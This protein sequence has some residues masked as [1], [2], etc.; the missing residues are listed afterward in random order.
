MVLIFLYP[1]YCMYNRLPNQPENIKLLIYFIFMFIVCLNVLKY[2]KH[3]NNKIGLLIA[4][5]YYSWC[6]ILITI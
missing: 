4:S 2:E 3:I 1:L 6:I 5:Q